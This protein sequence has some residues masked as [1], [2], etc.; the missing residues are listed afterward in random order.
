MKNLLLL[1]IINSCVYMI[2]CSQ[3]E[4]DVK[5]CLECGIKLNAE[6][7]QGKGY[8]QQCWTALMS[9][10]SG[11]TANERANDMT[12]AGGSGSAEKHY[13]IWGRDYNAA[14]K[15]A[16]AEGKSM[17]LLFTGSDWCPP[18]KNLHNTVL[19]TDHFKTELADEVVL[20]VLDNP[21]D[22]SLVS[23]PEQTQYEYLSG[24]FKVEGVPSLF[25]TDTTGKPY[26]NQVG[27][28]G[29]PAES[30][31]ANLKGKIKPIASAGK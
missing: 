2:G 21:R 28:G 19:V 5:V 11:K 24:Q 16:E 7:I 8:C 30:W 26:H 23:G 29:E 15:K 6:N 18:C 9:K 3:Q 22:K 12:A 10:Q 14:Q 20:V 13:K 31:V 27:Y 1:L 17:L 25:L 4:E